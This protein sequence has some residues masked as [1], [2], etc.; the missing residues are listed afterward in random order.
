MRIAAVNETAFYVYAYFRPD[1]QPCYVGKGKGARWLHRGKG[2]RNKHFIHIRDQANAA[3]CEMPRM[4]LVECLTADEALH[5]ERFFIAAI[6]R[7]VDGGPLVNLSLGG[8][9]GPVGYKWTPEL[10]AKNPRFKGRHH[11]PETRSVLSIQKKDMQRPPE[12]I[13][14][15]AAGRRGVS[16]K[17]G[18]WSTEEGRAKQ[19]ANNPGHTGYLHSEETKAI[20][21]AARLAQDEG[22]LKAT[23]FRLG[24]E[25]WNKGLKGFNPSPATQ[26]KKGYQPS[27]ETRK[28]LSA[29]VAASWARRKAAAL[30]Q[31]AQP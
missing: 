28:K 21:R 26:F 13:A 10:N 9:A 3:G 11:T 29:A 15:A 14:A 7:E 19:R 27:P 31:G 16:P 8:D 6:G 17:S 12:H 25:P 4:K 2:G 1:G 18:W 5:L 22:P 20:I 30:E 24:V 23:Q